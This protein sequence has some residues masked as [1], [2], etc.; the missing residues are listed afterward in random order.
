MME[1]NEKYTFIPTIL[2]DLQFH[3][4]IYHDLVGQYPE[5]EQI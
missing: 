5:E 2:G 1:K 3:N 4:Q